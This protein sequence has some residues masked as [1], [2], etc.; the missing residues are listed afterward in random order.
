MGVDPSGMGLVPSPMGPHEAQWP[1][2]SHE[3][4]RTQSR[5]GSHELECTHQAL[6]LPEL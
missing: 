4:G 2:L 3:H 5:G 1:P 6:H